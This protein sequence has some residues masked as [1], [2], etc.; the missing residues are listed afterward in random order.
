MQKAELK[1]APHNDFIIMGKKK[2]IKKNVIKIDDGDS[3]RKPPKSKKDDK[4]VE[5]DSLY[6]D[7]PSLE[8]VTIEFEGGDSIRIPP[9]PQKDDKKIADDSLYIDDLKEA[10]NIEFEGV[11]EV[12]SPAPDGQIVLPDGLHLIPIRKSKK[13]HIIEIAN[14]IDVRTIV[15]R[16]T[17]YGSNYDRKRFYVEKEIP[18]RNGDIRIIHAVKGGLWYVQKKTNEYLS[19]NYKPHVAAKGFIKE[20][21]IVKHSMIHRNKKLVMSFDIKDFFPTITFARVMGMFQAPPF[22][23]SREKSIVYAQICCLPEDNG[24]LPQGGITSPYISNM[25]CRKLDSRLLEY[26]KKEKFN[27]SRYADDLTFSSNENVNYG[28]LEKFVAK[29]LKEEGFQINKSKSRLMKKSDRQVVTGVVVNEGLNVNRKYIRSLRALI[30]NSIENGV[31]QEATKSQV[32]NN[33]K[34]QRPWDR[35][36]CS[37]FSMSA[38]GKYLKS[39]GRPFKYKDIVNGKFLS[40]RKQVIEHFKRH[41][42]GRLNHV[43]H[44]A[45]SNPNQKLR[46]R[47]L[48]IYNKLNK[49]W[50]IACTQDDY[51]KQFYIKTEGC[52]EYELERNQV[53]EATTIDDLDMIIKQLSNKRNDIRFFV[54]N[55]SDRRDE[56][57][58]E[59]LNF[60]KFPALNIEKTQVFLENLSQSGSGI[61]AKMIHKDDSITKEE[62]EERFKLFND[63]RH[64]L[65]INLQGLVKSFFKGYLKYFRENDLTELKPGDHPN[66]WDNLIVDFKNNTRFYT[67]GEDKNS[68]IFN[69]F[70][71]K[72]LH[73]KNKKYIK[74]K[75]PF[76]IDLDEVAEHGNCDIY[77]ETLAVRRA[78]PRLIESTLKN[79]K[80]GL[81]ITLKSKF[82][83]EGQ[84]GHLFSIENDDDSNL[85][86]R[87]WINRG[88]F[89]RKLKEV[90]RLLNGLANWYITF[91]TDSGRVT[92][93]VYNNDIDCTLYQ[94]GNGFKHT[95]I[96]PSPS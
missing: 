10:A 19:N 38:D 58:K 88:C 43:K 53:K 70:V 45:E 24:S 74:N 6:I 56:K 15:L 65:S 85:D 81:N 2:K 84:I 57:K 54:K 22:K 96:F 76:T 66:L 69:Q 4:N 12:G 18:K 77:T 89:N 37:P 55:F 95:F 82:Q 44:I 8:N 29:I 64:Y 91:N 25:I 90:L 59:M 78:L 42:N 93:D 11:T 31:Y 32:V 60:L 40:P 28:K 80:R 46:E 7:D 51:L 16:S 48:G 92:Y 62:I 30:Y 49:Q 71:I 79:S 13:I 34:R 94:D 27:Y 72:T 33:D 41:V 68:I 21:G 67:R 86:K 83:F 1:E 63:D 61:L 50:K 20:G 87:I 36:S 52:S 23:F 47:R 73:A 14:A 3:I 39:N 5:K 9:N 35:I 26:A 75:K 17:L